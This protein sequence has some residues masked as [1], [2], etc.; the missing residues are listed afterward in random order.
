MDSIEINGYKSIKHLK[1]DLRPVNIL[2]G[3]NGAGKSNFISFFEFLNNL[4]ER[5]LQQY[6]AT[7]GGM[8]KFLHKGLKKTDGIFANLTFTNE[9]NRQPDLIRILCIKC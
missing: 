6:V 7:H 4:Y 5:K 9:G 2:I 3:S 1:I 8:A